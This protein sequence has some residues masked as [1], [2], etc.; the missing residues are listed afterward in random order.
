MTRRE[1]SCVAELIAKSALGGRA[2]LTRGLLRLAETALGPV[3]SIAIFPGQEKNISKALKP[4]GLTF[5]LPNQ[6]ASKGDARLVWTG[7]D[8]AFLFGATLPD[9]PMTVA[10]TTDQTDAWAGLTLEGPGAD[11]ALMRLVPLDL[12]L[13]QFGLGQVRRVP[14]YHM[15]AIILRTAP[16]GFDLL[17]FRSM[18]RT[19]WHEIDTAMT[20]IEARAA[21][22]R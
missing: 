16:N 3:T 22:S 4:L 11:E 15:Q 2:P 7:R 19:A 10:A 12:R 13:A 5:P 8:Q 18:A 17:V 20:T 21:R 1:G 9:V 6:I 14:I